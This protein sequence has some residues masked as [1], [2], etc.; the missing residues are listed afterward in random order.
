MF[1]T[2][3]DWQTKTRVFVRVIQDRPEHGQA[4]PDCRILQ[5]LFTQLFDVSIYRVFIN[6]CDILSGEVF[7]QM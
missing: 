7:V 2:W 5:S 4:S 3:N 6:L 1:K